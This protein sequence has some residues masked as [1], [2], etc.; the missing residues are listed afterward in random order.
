MI[1]RAAADRVFSAV[2]KV[3]TLVAVLALAFVLYFIVS[4]ALP[5]F[6]EVSLADFLL[7]QRWMPIAYVGEPTYGIFNFIAGTVYV[8]AE[9]L[10]FAAVVGV[11]TSLWLAFVASD[12]ARG[13]LYPFIDLLAGVP[14]VVYGFVGLQVVVKLFL[15][16]GVHTGLCVLAAGIVLAVM[17]LPYSL[18]DHR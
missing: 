17:L 18:L 11:G 14:S 13:L 15:Q 8:S 3:L 5:L 1:I 16:A 7:G 12:K 6:E 2:V 10:V 4:E 9:A